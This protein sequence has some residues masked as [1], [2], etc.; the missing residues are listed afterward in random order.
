MINNKQ[1]LHDLQGCAQRRCAQILNPI[2]NFAFI[3]CENYLIQCNI[4]KGLKFMR[5][6]TPCRSRNISK[7][8]FNHLYK[9]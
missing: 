2:E 6:R 5:T 7:I 3:F 9:V 8:T 4:E 1:I